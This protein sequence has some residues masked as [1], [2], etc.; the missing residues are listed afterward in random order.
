MHSR[1]PLLAN[2]KIVAS[3]EWREPI[4]DG[5]QKHRRFIFLT[6]F[7]V[8][9]TG[10]GPQGRRAT[11]RALLARALRERA[12]AAEAEKTR[13]AFNREHKINPPA[14]IWPGPSEKPASWWRAAA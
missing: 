10:A 5:Q 14:V 4:R 11:K 12:G 7:G 9:S 2:P 1:A 3:D 6:Q 13:Q 8:G